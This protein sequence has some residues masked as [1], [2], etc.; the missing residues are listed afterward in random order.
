MMV[1]I[2]NFDRIRIGRFPIS[3]DIQKEAVHSCYAISA[4]V[5]LYNHP[6]SPA[7][8]ELRYKKAFYN[9]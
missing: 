5:H 9:L 3:F 6:D 2:Q 1:D 4:G 8:I 7:K